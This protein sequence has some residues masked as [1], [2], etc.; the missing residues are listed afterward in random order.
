MTVA[1]GFTLAVAGDLLGPWAPRMGQGNAGL[2]AVAALFTSADAGF[3]NLEGNIFDLVDFRGSPAAE[4]GGFEQ[5][6]IGSGPLY[7]CSVADDLRELGITMV[8]VANNH[9]LDWGAEGLLETG[10]TLDAAG[11]VHA[12]GGR[13]LAAARAPAFSETARGR[14]ALVSAASTFLP[15]AP[16]GAGGGDARY[17]YRAPRPGI[18]ALRKRTVTLVTEEEFAVLRSIADRQG[19]GVADDAIDVVINPNYETFAPQNFRLADR[20]GVTYEPFPED[21]DGILDAVRVG[22]T[23]A[24][25]V[26]FAIHA[27]ETSS[28][29]QEFLVP[30]E[31]LEPPDFVVDLARD[32][33]DA[34][35]DAVLVHGPH[36]VRGIEIHR[37]RPVFYGLGSLFFELGIGWPPS[38]YDSVVPVIRFDGGTLAEIR[39]HPISLGHPDERRPQSR[40]GIPEPADEETADRILTGI[41]RSSERYG[42]SVDITAGIGVIRDL[43][44]PPMEL[45]GVTG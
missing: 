45:E 18:S 21:R 1:D 26:V 11:I 37:D 33:I 17:P 12:G 36:V 35:A 44:D 29:G 15:M 8:S 10:R 14:V 42:T 27:Q 3:A 7:P 22:R 34:G 31:T 40:Q 13:T 5:G 25:F 30:P 2:G 6:G 20:T 39:L 4:N 43:A 16:A 41:R 24:D 23:R 9:A 28:G 19:T 38:W 32:A